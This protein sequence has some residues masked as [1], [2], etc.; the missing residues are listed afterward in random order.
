MSDFLLQHAGKVLSRFNLAEQLWENTVE[1]E[2]SAVDVAIR[3]LRAKLE[4]PFEVT[5]L[6]SVRDAD[7]VLERGT[8]AD[9]D[10]LR[11]AAFRPVTYDEATTGATTFSVRRFAESACSPAQNMRGGLQQSLISALFRW[12]HPSGARDTLPYEKPF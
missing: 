1:H 12:F 10:D 9:T 4:A 7:Y 8:D 3:R 6:H 2:S 5:L 11:E